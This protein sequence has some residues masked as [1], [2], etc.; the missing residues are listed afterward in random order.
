MQPD[1][2]DLRKRLDEIDNSLIILLAE[3]FKVTQEVGEY[4]RDNNVPPVDPAREAAIFERIEQTAENN[5]LNPEFAN[6]LIQ[7]IIAEVLKNHQT[8]QRQV[9]E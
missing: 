3:R 1:L 4:K 2:D 9:S 8:L 6:R 5:G 7:F